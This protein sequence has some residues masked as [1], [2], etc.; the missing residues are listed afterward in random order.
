M[1]VKCPHCSTE[2][3]GYYLDRSRCGSCHKPLTANSPQTPTAKPIDHTDQRI[4]DLE[5]ELDRAKETS[6]IFGDKLKKS[7]KAE[8][9]FIDAAAVI[10]AHTVPLR[11]I[12][13]TP[14]VVKDGAAD[15]DLVL[16]LS[17]EHA[18]QQITAA[19]TWGLERYDFNVFRCRLDRLKRQTINYA[20]KHLPR[21]EF[22]RLWILKLG[23]SVNGDIH[24]KG[25]KNFFGNTIKAALSVGDAEAQF[26]QSLIPHFSGG[27][28]VVSVAGNH[29]RR[30]MRK[31][32]E[33]PN[34]NF[35]YLVS[36]QMATRLQREIDAGRASVH[37]P[38]AWTAFV[39]IRGRVWALNHGDDVIGF[40][41]IPWYGF[42]RK[43]N[44]VQ[45][46]TARFDQKISYFCYGHFHTPMSFPSGG[47]ESIHSGAWPMTDPYAINKL[48][49]G[50]EPRQ[51]LY[52]V[53]DELGVILT[54][55]IFTRNA[56]KESRCL[57][58]EYEPEIGNRLII[59]SVTTDRDVGEFPLYRAP[60]AA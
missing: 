57:A 36:T 14:T 44:R 37:I 10:R 52:A 3:K 7:R 56:E 32:Y 23:D 27:V 54:I 49:A 28:H 11:P 21:H 20:V 5:R 47:G 59:D 43:N 58:G 30:S 48:S 4:L 24:G 33:G 29:P 39:E 55:P 50:N 2:T 8:D 34:D 17:D 13:S 18:D 12:A 22:R 38:D 35:D 16:L 9:L 46:L 51:T 40:A 41:G 6:R 25:P 26:V 15:C 31:D 60:D 19:G 1:R 53:D 42:E 45:N